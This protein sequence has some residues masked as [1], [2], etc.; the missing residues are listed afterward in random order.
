MRV[1]LIPCKR[2]FL[3]SLQISCLSSFGL[4]REETVV[5]ILSVSLSFSGL[6][7]KIAFGYRLQDKYRDWRERIGYQNWS[8]PGTQPFHLFSLFLRLH[9]MNWPSVT[10]SLGLIF[11]SRSP[12]SFHLHRLGH[13]IIISIIRTV[14]RYSLNRKESLW[15]IICQL[16][17]NR[18]IITVIRVIPLLSS[19]I[20]VLFLFPSWFPVPPS[21]ITWSRTITIPT[22]QTIFPSFLAEGN[23]EVRHLRNLFLSLNIIHTSFRTKETTI[24]V[25]FHL[26]VRN[27]KKAA[28]TIQ[29]IALQ[30]WVTFSLLPTTI[31]TQLP[32]IECH[33]III[34]PL[35]KEQEHLQGKFILFF[36]FT[37]CLNLIEHSMELC[38]KISIDTCVKYLWLLVNQETVLIHV[39]P[40]DDEDD[41]EEKAGAW[42]LLLLRLLFVCFFFVSSFVS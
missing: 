4:K 25:A 21:S 5:V 42:I 35:P 27:T 36:S 1:A 15:S 19:R 2:R 34:N 38:R 8:I 11:T 3:A 26:K 10:V 29:R 17:N 37:A 18:Y 39:T 32:P 24:I 22:L 23:T 14:S 13:F 9:W 16:V 31:V 30:D 12:Y 7:K 41:D 33:E 20:K 28:W 40:A 6:F